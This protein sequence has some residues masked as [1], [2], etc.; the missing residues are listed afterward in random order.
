MHYPA[1]GLFP[2]IVVIVASFLT[3]IHYPCGTLFLIPSFHVS[4]TVPN[5]KV[6]Q[7]LNLLEAEFGLGNAIS[8]WSRGASA[9]SGEEQSDRQG[10]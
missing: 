1:I 5:A 2:I 9:G 6:Q 4:V 10:L 3:I 8:E 7:F